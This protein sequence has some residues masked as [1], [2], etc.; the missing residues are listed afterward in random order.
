MKRR[1]HI[2]WC[3]VWVPG[4]KDGPGL[5]R[6]LI[7]G[8]SIAQS[9]FDGVEKR[10]EGRFRC[11][12]LTTS[13]CAGDPQLKRELAL[14]LGEFQFSVIHFNNGLHGWDFTEAEYAKGLAGA[15]DFI[16]ARSPES[17][18]LWASTT[19]VWSAGAS[20]AL[21]EA[22]TRRVR[23][24]N[25][26]ARKIAAA[27]RIAVNDLYPAVIG[28]RDMVSQDGVHFI[29][30]GQQALAERVARFILRNAKGARIRRAG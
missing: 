24:R 27:R 6:I 12:R 30:A 20:G 16:R 8:D 29:P 5:P 13:R 22:T 19:P 10:L 25:R 9:Y 2:E 4:A 1:E 28:R 23:E 14:L 11:A 26:L 21:D 15:L 17:L 3:N 18:L 7:A